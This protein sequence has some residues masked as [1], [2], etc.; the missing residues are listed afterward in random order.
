[1]NEEEEEKEAG[2]EPEP[3]SSPQRMEPATAASATSLANS[4]SSSKPGGAS[5]IASSSSIISPCST[6]A[7]LKTHTLLGSDE[8]SKHLRDRQAVFQ[9]TTWN[10]GSLPLPDEH[11]LRKIFY[12]YPHH[13]YQ[14]EQP[15]P[16]EEDINVDVHV[17]AIQECWPE[18]DALELQMQMCLCPQFALF[19]SVS[20]GTLHLSIFIRRDLLWF[21]TGGPRNNTHILFY[22]HKS[23]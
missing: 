21:T 23:F 7:V 13:H 17:V 10:M 8:L 6:P 22:G 20:F 15:Y 14:S 9:I 1:M 18:A 12:H 11:H 19:H 3:S 16:P 4:T 2:E 5:G